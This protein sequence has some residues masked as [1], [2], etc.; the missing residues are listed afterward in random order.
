MLELEM[1]NPVLPQ[2]FDA[3]SSTAPL[4]S[5]VAPHAVTPSC[6]PPAAKRPRLPAA[7]GVLER[8]KFGFTHLARPKVDA[9]SLMQQS[10]D[11]MQVDIDYY[12]KGPDSRFP[13]PDN[14][15]R[16]DTVV[17]VLRMYGVTE[18]GHSV[19]AHIHGFEPYFYTECP[20]E[21]EEQP[22]I[23]GQTLED[24]LANAGGREKASP[25]V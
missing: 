20:I 23:F 16:P 17:P 24:L 12:S 19:L 11:V 3:S 22:E 6:E 1:A 21:L 5:P 14:P 15:L 25:F 13:N 10:L 9:Q 7:Y 2:K 18:Q 8:N 4:S